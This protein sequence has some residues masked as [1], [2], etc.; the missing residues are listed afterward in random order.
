M[1]R[2]DVPPGWLV[3]AVDVGGQVYCLE[4]GSLADGEPLCEDELAARHD[5]QEDVMCAVCGCVLS[6]IL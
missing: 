3:V 1:R 4:C 5:G 2:E 6:V